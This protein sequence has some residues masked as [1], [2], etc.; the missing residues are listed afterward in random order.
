MAS[1]ITLV[2]LAVLILHVVESEDIGCIVQCGLFTLLLRSYCIYFA[3]FLFS[4]GLSSAHS[5]SS[6]ER[7]RNFI[8]GTVFLL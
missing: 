8:H 1:F 3:R 5:A 2:H 4:H 6:T 7:Y